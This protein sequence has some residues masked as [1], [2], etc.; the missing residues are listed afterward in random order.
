MPD[1]ANHVFVLQFSNPVELLIYVFLLLWV[2]DTNSNI[3]Q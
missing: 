2:I 3:Y 1:I